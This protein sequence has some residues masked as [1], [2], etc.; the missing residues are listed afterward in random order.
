METEENI[1]AFEPRMLLLRELERRCQQ[2]P[3]YSMRA[4]AKALGL[5]PAMLSL[6]IAGRRGL[7]RSAA[8]KVSTCLGLSPQDAQ[9]FIRNAARARTMAPPSLGEFSQ[10]SL[11]QFAVIA[12]WHHFGILSLIETDGFSPRIPSIASRL[13]ITPSEAK[14]AVERLVRLGLLDASGT[15][16]K[17]VG[18][19]VFVA[20]DTSTSATR[21]HQ[22]QV[23]EGAAYSLENDPFELRE[24][25]SVTLAMDPKL[26]PYARQEIRKFLMRLMTDLESKGKPREVYQ[27]SVQAFPV[28]RNRGN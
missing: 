17:Q 14:A 13:G 22:R 15:K 2:N 24:L 16:W 19:P 26:V 5:S 3:R 12:D 21:K 20:N 25:N 11:D 9:H 1:S 8:R 27:L 28:S 6:V 7:S 10:L 4:F 18:A 23:L